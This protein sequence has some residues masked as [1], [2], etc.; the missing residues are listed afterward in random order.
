M[1]IPSIAGLICTLLYQILVF[2]I[3]KILSRPMELRLFL[4]LNS[5]E[6]DPISFSKINYYVESIGQIVMIMAIVGAITSIITTS[7]ILFNL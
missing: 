4:G 5:S 2:L 7:Y 3:G 6:E 1:I